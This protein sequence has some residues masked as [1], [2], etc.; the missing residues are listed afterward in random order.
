MRAA[1][2]TLRGLLG[3]LAVAASVVATGPP[4]GAGS[5]D[6]DDPVDRVLIY[7]L[8]GV[9]WEDVRGADMPHLEGLVEDSAVGVM[10]TQIGR[11]PASTTAG[12][13]TIGAGTRAVVPGVDVAVA[14]NPDELLGGVSAADILRRRIGRTQEG[15]AYLPFGAAV[16]VNEGSAY[17]AVPGTLGQSLAEQKVG[18]AVIA[19]ADSAEGFPLDEPLPDGAFARSAVTALMGADGIVPDGTVGRELLV[20]DRDAPFG[21]RMAPDRVLAAFDDVWDTERQQVVLVEASDLVRTN[22]YA[23]RATAGQRRAL[24]Q[25]ALADSDAMLGELLERIDPET[26][27]V[28]VV[29]P[30]ASGAAGVAVLSAPGVEPGLL[31]SAT[32]RRGGYVVLADVAPTVLD[33]VGIEPPTSIEGRSFTIESS[34]GDR[35]GTLI[36]Q[37]AAALARDARLPTVVQ[38]VIAALAVL[39]GLAVLGDRVHRR[40]RAAVVPCAFG[41]L[42]VVPGT[43]LAGQVGATTSSGTAYAAVVLT[44]ATFVGGVG[45]IVDRRQPG[46]GI[47]VGLASIVG[48]IGADV[49]LGARLQVN[50]VFGYSTAVAGRFAGLGNLAFALFGAATLCLGVLVVDRWGPRWRTPVLVG[51]GLVVLVEG[52]PMLGADVGG[53]ASMV[54]AFILVGLVLRG[55]R[56]RWV[57]VALS[58][59]AS[60]TAVVAFGLLDAS[61]PPG[62]QTHLARLGD[63]LVHGRFGSVTSTLVRRLHASFGTTETAVVCL[64]LGV[65][66]AAAVHG[67]VVGR[68]RGRLLGRIRPRDLTGAALGTGLGVLATLGLVVNDSSIAVPATMLIVIVPVMLERHVRAP[69]RPTDDAVD[70]DREPAGVAP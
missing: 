26:D 70:D 43:F 16:D 30:V 61:R 37:R 47:L 15:I 25:R 42:G 8:P 6:R 35:V 44:V 66:I 1:R 49:L 23:S 59:V 52:L 17:G 33:L 36:D 65:V 10:S 5:I 57:H 40:V 14:L 24:Q 45:W 28:L 51:F 54:P 22:A 41:V 67:A 60:F 56:I 4:V 34:D 63:H 48:L 50:T 29:S 2:R 21:R 20:E 19:N 31:R 58:A 13:L 12:Y 68:D 62:S 7:T 9:T 69:D 32:T 55:E 46:S 39:T 11:A 38:V 27:A 18:R 53:V 3:L 64:A